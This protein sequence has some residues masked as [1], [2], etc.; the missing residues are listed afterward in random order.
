MHVAL[1]SVFGSKPAK[2]REQ[3][4]FAAEGFGPH[5]SKE[6]Q[7]IRRKCL[8]QIFAPALPPPW[9]GARVAMQPDFS[10]QTFTSATRHIYI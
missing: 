7:F 5:G 2:E 3:R 9:T 6:P 10:P 8:S 4:A 1:L